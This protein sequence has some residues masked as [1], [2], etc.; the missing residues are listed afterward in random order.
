MII[1]PEGIINVK[2]TTRYVRD[3]RGRFVRSKGEY[4]A[5]KRL[6]DKRGH[7]KRDRRVR[8]R[9]EEV[10]SRMTKLVIDA[11]TGRARTYVFRNFS[12]AY[13]ARLID[14][15]EARGAVWSPAPSL[16]QRRLATGN[17]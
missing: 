16:D 11:V 12:R 1:V 13:L 15:E 2:L 5:F 6:R 3:K 17:V 8:Y 7:F 10:Y 14:E 4:V 9:T